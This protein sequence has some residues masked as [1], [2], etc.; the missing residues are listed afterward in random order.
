[1]SDN[2]LTLQLA[3]QRYTDNFGYEVGEP[4][5]ASVCRVLSQQIGIAKVDKTLPPDW[6]Q[7][8]PSLRWVGRAPRG[9]TLFHRRANDGGG[10]EGEEQ[11]VVVSGYP[12]TLRFT[13]RYTTR[14][15]AYD[16]SGYD[17]LFMKYVNA[18]MEKVVTDL[19]RLELPV[20]FADG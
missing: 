15:G 19:D 9:G 7:P 18:N 13:M 1:M 10:E 4:Q 3:C 8:Q 11:K 6:G 2:N 12:L 5:L 16:I 17:Q 20:V 14:V